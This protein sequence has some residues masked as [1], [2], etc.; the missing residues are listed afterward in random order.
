[1]NI[2][3]F[4]VE[5][6]FHILDNPESNNEIRWSKFESR[7]H[8]NMEK[9]LS[10]LEAK[11]QQATFFCLGWIAEKHPDVIR[12]IDAA[13]HE[14]GSHSQMHQLAYE[15]TPKTFSEDLS[16]SIRTLEDLIGKKIKSYRAPGFSLIPG[17]EWA[18]DALV[19]LG[20]EV[21]CSVFP[22][23]RSHGGFPGFGSAEPSV[24]RWSGGSIR[25]FPINVFPILGV[26]VVFSGGGYFRLMPYWAIKRMMQSTHY[27]MTYFHPRDF[28]PG[29][30]MMPGL[31]ATR[32][33][34]S[35]YGLGS[36]YGKLRSLLD[37][38]EFEDLRTVN[39]QTDWSK[40]NV[41]IL[42]GGTDSARKK[43]QAF[44]TAS[45][46]IDDVRREEISDRYSGGNQGRG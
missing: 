36:A 17:M 11:G 41:F 24:I 4:D 38:F 37:A 25:E 3:T 10:L 22:A 21:D 44:E 32:R 43:T 27:V 29:Q 42:D 30:P 5:D 46:R 28:D 19:S 18:F 9:L 16:R 33:F 20:I 6:W 39:A 15:Q 1:M 45:A 13:G 2:L 26:N 31:S 7:I 12:R 34:K 35:Y 23:R 40:A 8:G 14:I